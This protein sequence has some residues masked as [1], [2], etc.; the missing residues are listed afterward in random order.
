MIILDINIRRNPL[1]TTQL[2]LGTARLENVPVI[3]VEGGVLPLNLLAAQPGAVRAAALEWQTS[4]NLPYGI[5]HVPSQ[6]V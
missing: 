4:E 1:T 2:Y 5:R 6:G 3:T